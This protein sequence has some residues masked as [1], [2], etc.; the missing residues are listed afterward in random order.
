MNPSRTQQDFEPEIVVLYC[1]RA[2]AP[3]PAEH[4]RPLHLRE[5]VVPCTSKIEI[6]HLLKILEQGA[7]AVQVVG[8]PEGDCQFLTGSRRT[9]RRIE[10]ARKL[11]AEA[12][13][14]E[15]RL[16]MERARA[17]EGTGLLELAGRRAAAVAPLGPNPMKN[18]GHP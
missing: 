2:A 18:A 13:M 9:E 10:F 16:A 3:P 14:G 15:E 7:D 17:M 8:C 12:G 1:E 11:L 5:V 4:D 6:S